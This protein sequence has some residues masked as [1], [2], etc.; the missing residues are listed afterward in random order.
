MNDKDI[1]AINVDDFIREKKL[2]N[3]KYIRWGKNGQKYF[4]NF[5]KSLYDFEHYRYPKTFFNGFTF[6]GIKHYKR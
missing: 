5:V 6:M 3:A 4:K 1:T 2:K